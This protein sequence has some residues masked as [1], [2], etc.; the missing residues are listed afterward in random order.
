MIDPLTMLAIGQ[1]VAK[2]IGDGAEAQRTEAR[3]QENRVRAAAARDLKIQGINRR[4][5]QESEVAAEQK[6]QMAIAALKKEER[7][8]VAAGEAGITG[9]SVDAVTSQY[10]TQKLRDYTT[11]NT[12]LV[13]LEKQIELEKLGA[14]AEA[15]ARINSLPRGIMPNILVAALGTAAQAYATEL[16]M[17]TDMPDKYSSVFGSSKSAQQLKLDAAWT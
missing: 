15:E 16:K 2:F 10:E 14:S 12:N 17:K 5:I 3:F 6:Q 8:K 9:S 1:G 11:I 4:L 7:A 13:N